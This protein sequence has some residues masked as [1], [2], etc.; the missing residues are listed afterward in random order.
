MW[1][2]RRPP[3]RPQ[4]NWE[5]WEVAV[6]LTCRLAVALLPALLFIV[7]CGGTLAPAPAADPASQAAPRPNVST[8]LERPSAIGAARPP[9]RGSAST[10]VAASASRVATDSA[11]VPAFGHIFLIVLENTEYD[12]VAG[13]SSAP[14]LNAL[15]AQFGLATEYYAVAHPSLPNY[16]ALLGGQTYG[17]TNDCLDCYQSAANLAD[18]IEASGRSWKGYF[19]SMPRAC[20]AGDSADGLYRQKHNPFIYFDR[21]RQDPARCARLV[22]LDQLWTDLA[23]GGLPEF[24]WIGPNMRSS[25]HDAPLDEGDRWLAS[26]LPRVLASPAFQRDGL[27]VVTFDEGQTTLGCCG[28]NVGGGR[29]MTV[30]ASPLV[31]PGFKSTVAYNHYSLLR[32]IEDAWGLDRLGHAAD[33]PTRNLAE[34]FAPQTP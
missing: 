29:V 33:P 2:G 19:E 24:V 3:A 28:R 7:A 6:A 9:V 1:M 14:Y 15:G 11:G 25:L 13:N 26:V 34:F 18:Q 32:T 27:L 31:R 5:L 17:V 30:L 8:D 10:P 4:A 21:I 23:S 20:F 12:R 22:P 16:L